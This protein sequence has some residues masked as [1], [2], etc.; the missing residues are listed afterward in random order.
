LREVPM[1]LTYDP[2]HNIAYI[3]LRETGGQQVETLPISDELN[4]DLAPDGTTLGIEL[5]NAKEQLKSAD[6]ARLLVENRAVGETRELA[7]R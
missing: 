5:L 6:G 3:R 7:L 4:I 2:E 1:R